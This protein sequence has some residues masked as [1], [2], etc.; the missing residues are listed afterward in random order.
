MQ[1]TLSSTVS[2]ATGFVEDSIAATKGSFD[3]I[4]TGIFGAVQSVQDT[5]S[6]TVSS[7]TKSVSGAG[8]EVSSQL[9]A[10]ADSLLK[11]LREIGTPLKS[12]IDQATAGLTDTA[13]R[14]S[15]EVEGALPPEARDVLLSAKKTAGELSGPLQEVLKEVG[16]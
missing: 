11:P 1:E 2:G 4:K 6:N 10:Q 5:F 7:T 9:T 13:S 12:A 8:S 16:G 14:V 15:Q 3:G